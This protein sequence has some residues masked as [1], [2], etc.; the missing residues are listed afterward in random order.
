[1]QR[2]RLAA[3]GGLILALAGC[4]QP[5]V[6]ARPAMW[7]VSDGD[8]TVWLLGSIHL[9]PANVAWRTPLI[10]RA[11]AESDTLVLESSPDDRGDFDATATGTGL[12]PVASRVSPGKRPALEAMIARTG[13][14]RAKLDR[15]KN[16]A[17]AAMLE[18]G[19]AIADGASLKNGVEEK[20]WGAFDQAGKT[21]T[22]F[23]R[24][25]EQLSL[26]DTLPDELQREMLE[27]TLLEKENYRETLKAWETGDVASLE[28]HATCT[29]LDG[30]LVGQPNDR[31]SKWIAWRM[32]QPG[33]LLVAVGLGHLVGPYALPKLLAA[34][35]L[36]VERVQ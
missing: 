17:V 8:T 28:K 3:L 32:R 33:T 2:R 35:G 18:T 29:P 14:P 36:K 12:P 1:M 15:Y 5:T 13:A 31:W 26:L 6:E 34:R 19:S 10:D 16:W 21:R 25:K 7:R 22:V 4:G 30:R 20:L 24:V 27:N 23:Y 9:L 11:I